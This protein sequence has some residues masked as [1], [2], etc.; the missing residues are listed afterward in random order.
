MEF[1]FDKLNRM[2]NFGKSFICRFYWFIHF[3]MFKLCFFVLLI[4]VSFR[5]AAARML[6]L[7]EVLRLV[8]P[9]LPVLISSI[10]QNYKIIFEKMILLCILICSCFSPNILVV[11]TTRM[12]GQ[13]GIFDIIFIFKNTLGLW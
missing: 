6:I 3:E 11:I 8:L 2:E 12:F 9:S 4:T 5:K 1:I 7:F 13:L 10:Y